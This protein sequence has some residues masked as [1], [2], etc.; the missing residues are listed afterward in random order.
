MS[1]IEIREKL[2]ALQKAAK[3]GPPSGVV[4][5]VDK[6]GPFM[7]IPPGAGLGPGKNPTAVGDLGSSKPGGR[8]D[9]HGKEGPPPE[10]LGGDI[11]PALTPWYQDW[12]YMLPLAAGGG[13]GAYGLYQLLA[14]KKKRNKEA[15]VHAEVLSRLAQAS[16]RR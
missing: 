11:P 15:Q 8:G 3:P 10:G 4:P 7:D 16:L 13:L 5:G 9:S 12:R 14:R 1:W 2:A 6:P